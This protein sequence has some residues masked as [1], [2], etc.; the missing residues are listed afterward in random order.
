M[1]KTSRS[2][3]VFVCTLLVTPIVAFAQ[4]TDD[5]AGGHKISDLLFTV[6]PFV[7]IGFLFWLFFIRTIQKQQKSPAFKRHQDF[8]DRQTQAR[9]LQSSPCPNCR[10]PA[11]ALEKTQ[12]SAA[13]VRPESQRALGVRDK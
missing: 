6:V 5:G 8:Q 11:G 12:S 7:A 10:R 4:A 1:F 2:P 13:V 3:W 9:I